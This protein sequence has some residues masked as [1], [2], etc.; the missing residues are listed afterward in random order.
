M[1]RA[2]KVSKP[3]DKSE[4]KP[5]VVR[6]TGDDSNK[7]FTRLTEEG[8]YYPRKIANET[9]EEIVKIMKESIREGYFS[10][11]ALMLLPEPARTHALACLHGHL[12]YRDWTDFNC[13]AELKKISDDVE[14]K[15]FTLK[16]GKEI[17]RFY[18][19]RQD[20]NGRTK[21]KPVDHINDLYTEMKK[22][23][24]I[25]MKS[26]FAVIALYKHCKEAHAVIGRPGNPSAG[27]QGDHL[28]E[29]GGTIDV[30][31]V[32]YTYKLSE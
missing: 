23:D 2:K 31:G 1:P 29:A 10:I 21:R 12:G 26:N 24:L 19:I 17:Q 9:S 30:D 11:T 3:K 27:I 4:E 14:G 28:R 15:K 25:K 32:Q 16:S 20:S 8:A 5:F 6:V 22:G 7:F 13:R 18:E